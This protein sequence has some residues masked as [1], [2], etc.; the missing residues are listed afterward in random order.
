MM[1]GCGALLPLSEMKA[2]EPAVKTYGG[3][4]PGQTFTFTVTDRT[5]TKTRGTKVTKNVP[6]PNGIPDFAEGQTVKFTIG[7]KGQ[8]KGSGFSIR[9]RSDKGDVNLYSNNPSTSSIAG[10]AATVSKTRRDRPTDATLT[11]YRVRFSGFV[12]ISHFVQ[13]DLE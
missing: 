5:S 8:L 12:P 13:Y 4:T 2:A 11:F 1:I 7:A 9:Y 3:F 10:E 6:V